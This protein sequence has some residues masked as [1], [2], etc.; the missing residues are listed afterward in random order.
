[1]CRV[2]YIGAL[3]LA[4]A[5]GACLLIARGL[6]STNENSL[7]PPRPPSAVVPRSIDLGER[8]LQEVVY[9]RLPISN[10]GDLDLRLFAFHT[11]CSCTVISDAENRAGETPSEMVIP[12]G[13]TKELLLQT[14]VGGVPNMASVIR[15]EFRTNDPE[16][17]L[18]SV[19][20]RTARV[21]GGVRASPPAILVGDTTAR[22]RAEYTVE[23]RDDSPTA[24]RIV[25]VVATLPDQCK[26][27]TYVSVASAGPPDDHVI[28]TLTVV[29]DLSSVRNIDFEVVASLGPD[30][31]ESIRIPVR[32]RVVPAIG[33]TPDRLFFPRASLEGNV[34]VSRCILVSN[35]GTPVNIVSYRAPAG[36]KCTFASEKRTRLWIDV[37]VDEG[38]HDGAYELAF[39]VAARGGTH[40]VKVPLTV[41]RSQ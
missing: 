28:G 13:V 11:G 10:A 3:G 1:M 23:L 32:G 35:E 39:E 16:L 9:S 14:R 20:L 15:V 30:G 37:S 18:A 29:L 33:C 38:L 12:P 4:L 36:V 34:F 22:G 2:A 19:A 21:R 8:E 26:D 31:R 24:R 25:S 41:R 5:G 7:S 40:L 27:L 17:P 6:R